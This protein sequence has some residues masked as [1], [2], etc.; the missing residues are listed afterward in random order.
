MTSSL[1]Q[2]HQL[3]KSFP[4]GGKTL[5][6]L[7]RVDFTIESEASSMVIFGPSGSGKSTLLYLLSSLEEPTSGDILFEGKSYQRM[8]DRELSFFRNQKMGF[9][10]QFH[11]LLPEF[12]A[13][14]NVM[15]PLLLQGVNKKEAM[16][17]SKGVLDRLGLLS[18]AEH[19]PSQLSGGE[20]QRVAVGRAIVHEPRIL[21][22]DEPT[23]NLDA[24]T[25]ESLV[26][27]MFR[28]HRD[29]K[30]A[31][32]MVTHNEKLASRFGHQLYLKQGHLNS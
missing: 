21:F 15:M 4:S 26:D 12:S 28:C 17:K 25:G 18:R 5:T 3:T 14:E 13:L 6:I 16:D 10:F 20:Q 19:R 2:A 9:V 22:A 23:G 29:Q 32:V 24:A 30:M 8:K 27:L 7:D 11:H 31:L 1:I